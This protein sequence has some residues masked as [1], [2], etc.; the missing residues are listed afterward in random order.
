[1][2]IIVFNNGAIVTKLKAGIAVEMLNF[3]ETKDN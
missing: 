1:M 2:V 3:K